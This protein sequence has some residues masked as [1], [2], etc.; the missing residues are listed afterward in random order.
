[1]LNIDAQKYTN[2]ECFNVIEAEFSGSL[3]L[4]K[5]TAQPVVVLF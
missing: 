5:R 2:I 4:G 1:V 3:D